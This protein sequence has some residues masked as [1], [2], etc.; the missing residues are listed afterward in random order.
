MAQGHLETRRKPGTLI[1]ASFVPV[2]FAK[3]QDVFASLEPCALHSK[4]NEVSLHGGR[5]QRQSEEKTS[6]TI[7]LHDIILDELFLKKDKKYLF[8]WAFFYLQN[9]SDNWRCFG[10]AHGN[11]FPSQ[12]INKCH[13]HS[14]NMQR[15]S[16]TVE[17]KK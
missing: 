5:T 9:A 13:Y 14:V 17:K 12:Q 6:P 7:I 11:C 15:T 16:Q 1:C 8:L 2:S 4:L 10:K 3:A